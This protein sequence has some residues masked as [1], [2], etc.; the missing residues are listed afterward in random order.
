MPPIE[1]DTDTLLNR[2]R[3]GDQSARQG[4]AGA[5]DTSFYACSFW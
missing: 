2:V 3:C 4:P 5:L 1:A